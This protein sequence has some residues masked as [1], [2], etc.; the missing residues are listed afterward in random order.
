MIDATQFGGDPAKCLINSVLESYTKLHGTVDPYIW[1]G[2]KTNPT[3]VGWA[4]KALSKLVDASK[5]YLKQYDWVGNVAKEA[6]LAIST[7]GY[8]YGNV[9]ALAQQFTRNNM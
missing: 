3:G 5:G 7:A 4:S 6:L 2:L 8:G 9:V 1:W